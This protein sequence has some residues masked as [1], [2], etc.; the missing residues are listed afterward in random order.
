MRRENRQIDNCLYEHTSTTRS[1]LP[2]AFEGLT[3]VSFTF[4][5]FLSF[6]SSCLLLPTQF[7]SIFYHSSYPILLTP[8]SPGSPPPP[9]FSRDK[10]EV[11]SGAASYGAKHKGLL[12]RRP[13]PAAALAAP[14]LTLDSLSRTA[15]HFT[16]TLQSL[17][18]YSKGGIWVSATRTCSCAPS[19]IDLSVISFIPFVGLALL[20]THLMNQPF[21]KQHAFAHSLFL[22]E[23]MFETNCCHKPQQEWLTSNHCHKTKLTFYRHRSWVHF[24]CLPRC[25]VGKLT[26]ASRQTLSSMRKRKSN[27][28]CE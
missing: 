13:G 18:I 1:F 10:E 12:L 24:E 17:F 23:N 4:S 25:S 27:F 9:P 21:S 11:I 2:A 16:L 6:T 7:W 28:C 20:S 19:G 8:V 5:P 26:E 22:H 15:P 3:R 14:L